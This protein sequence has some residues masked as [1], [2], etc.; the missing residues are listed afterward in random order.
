MND[1]REVKTQCDACNGTGIYCGFAEPK[2]TGVI[3]TG[4]NGSGCAV[5]RYKPFKRRQRKSGVK[6]V[7]PSRGRG[8]ITGVGS[9]GERMSYAEFLKDPKYSK[10]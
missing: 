10:P 8:L 1:Y 9:T 3:C 7:S 5:I 4:C 6:T 2:G